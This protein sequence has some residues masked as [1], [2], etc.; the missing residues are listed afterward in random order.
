MKNKLVKIVIAALTTIVL[1]NTNTLEVNNKDTSDI[2]LNN[3]IN[4]SSINKIQ[5]KNIEI[6]NIDSRKAF[7]RLT[8]ILEHRNGKIIIEIVSGVMLD[9]NGNGKDNAGKYI[10]YDNQ[11]F[12]KGDKIQSIF[13]YNPETNVNDDILYRIDT[14]IL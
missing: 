2:L 5:F 10:K 12:S 13:I 4:M 1:I 3:M 7:D 14:L 6:Y 8:P 11:E 9:D